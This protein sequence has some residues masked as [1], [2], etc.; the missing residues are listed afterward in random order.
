MQRD[1]WM[2]AARSL[3]ALE[4]PESVGRRAAER[5]LRRLGARSVADLRGAGDL[6]SAHA[7]S[8]WGQVAALVS[9]YA[10]YRGTSYLAGKLGERSRAS[11]SR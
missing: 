6:R 2:T 9:G 1:Y 8:L 7:A 4:S 10:V 11:A 3:A 5:A